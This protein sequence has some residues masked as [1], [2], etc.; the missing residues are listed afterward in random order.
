MLVNR[1]RGFV[2]AF[3]DAGEAVTYDQDLGAK[4]DYFLTNPKYLCE[5]QQSICE[6]IA[7]RFQLRQ[8]LT[9]VL[10]AAFSA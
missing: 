10:D 1:R 9:R 6:T 8:V 3:G 2:E 4:I 7:T 5:A